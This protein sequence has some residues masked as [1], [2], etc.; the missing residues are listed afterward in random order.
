LAKTKG[1]E[2]KSR[3]SK[4]KRRQLKG[5]KVAQP[6]DFWMKALTQQ[7]AQALVSFLLP[8]A[9]F[10]GTRDKELEART[11]E[12]D[13]LLNVIWR[14][15]EIIL[16]IEFQRKADKNMGLRVWEYNVVT[17][18]LTSCP[19]YSV[20]IYLEEESGIIEPPYKEEVLDE[21]V[22]VFFFRNLKLWEILPAVFKQ[23]GLDGLLPLL[24]LTQGGK[25]REMVEEMIAELKARDRADL[26]PYGWAFA[27][28]VLKE[29]ADIQWLQER[30]SAMKNLFQE[31]PVYKQIMQESLEK[32]LEQ[33]LEQG[34]QQGL[35]K[36][37]QQGLQQGGLQQL[38]QML[39]H[40][41]Q[42]RFPVLVPL[43]QEQAALIKDVEVLRNM[44]DAVID[45]ETMEEVRC[46]LKEAHHRPTTS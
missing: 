40:R 2:Q 43:A 29:I 30:F 13:L 16:H 33:G 45:A 14:G 44:I 12:A 46:R 25:S 35:E 22:H 39:V 27:G 34:L 15:I 10:L 28:L 11:I 21:L 5:S 4:A 31:F 42:K 8:G 32:G 7:E 20:V 24:P 23:S 19:V 6:W 41:V 3:L 37:L 36:G 9:Q 38:R 17:R 1:K 18:Y 26:L